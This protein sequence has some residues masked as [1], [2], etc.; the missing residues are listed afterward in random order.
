MQRK[1]EVNFKQRLTMRASVEAVCL[2][3]SRA[4]KR[5]WSRVSEG[6]SSGK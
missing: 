1:T 2:V 4:A 3:S 6:V 5:S